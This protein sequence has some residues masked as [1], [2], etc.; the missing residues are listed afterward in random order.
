MPGPCKQC[1]LR[2]Q[3]LR[4]ETNDGALLDG[5]S[6]TYRRGDA[7][8]LLTPTEVQILGYLMLAE[9]EWIP[10]DELSRVVHGGVHSHVRAHISSIRCKARLPLV[11]RAWHGYMYCTDAQLAEL[12]EA[13]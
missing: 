9:N 2:H 5:A 3:H 10:G 6:A 4:V 7:L 13:S 8:A 1:P 12:L 11:S